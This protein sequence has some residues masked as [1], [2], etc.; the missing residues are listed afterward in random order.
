MDHSTK[1]P[2]PHTLSSHGPE[3]KQPK[4]PKPQTL[5]KP[6]PP[7]QDWIDLALLLDSESL[8]CGETRRVYAIV[9]SDGSFTIDSRGPLGGRGGGVEVK[10]GGKAGGN[11]VAREGGGSAGGGGDGGGDDERKPTDGEED[12]VVAMGWNLRSDLRSVEVET[13]KP[14]ILDPRP[15]NPN[16]WTNLPDP[17]SCTTHS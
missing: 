4:T 17:T 15:P 2:K 6:D 16:L 11:Q 3:T 13:P 1:P 9:T 5:N 7:C 12:A 10:A 14:P 8:H